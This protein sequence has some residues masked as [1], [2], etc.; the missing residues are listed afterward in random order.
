[1]PQTRRVSGFQKNLQLMQEL[2]R[3]QE[4]KYTG[5]LMEESK[6]ANGKKNAQNK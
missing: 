2:A 4:E 6:Q 5:L 1:M 3:R